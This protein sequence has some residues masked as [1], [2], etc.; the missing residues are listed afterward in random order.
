MFDEIQTGVCRTGFWFAWMY[1]GVKPDVMTTAKAI[2]GGFPMG[3]F[4][5]TERLAHVFAPGDHGSTFGGNALS[6][7]ACYTAISEMKKLHLDEQ[8]AKTGEYFKAGLKGL[9][10]KYPDKITDV[11]GMGLILG[12]ELSKPGAP[13][14]KDGSPEKALLSTARGGERPA[15]CTAADYYRTRHRQTAPGSG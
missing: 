5:V 14:V 8:V 10:A 1:S 2:G 11:R 4:L 7:A 3:A 15:F 9:Q 12:A 13:L 6:C